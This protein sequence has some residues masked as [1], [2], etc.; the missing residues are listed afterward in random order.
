LVADWTATASSQTNDAIQITELR[1]TVEFLPHGLPQNSP[2][3]LPVVSNL[4]LEAHD[5]LR[6]GANSEVGILWPDNSVLRFGSLTELEILSADEIH[7]DRGLHLISGLLSF[8]HRGKPGRIRVITSGAFAGIEGTEF[9]VEVE[10]SNGVE[11]TTLSVIDGKVSFTNAMGGLMLTNGEQAVAH[12]GAAPVRT[13]GFIANNVLQ[14][15]FY[16]P[17]VLDTKELPGFTDEEK[18]SLG[19]SLAEYRAGDLLAAL[20]EFTDRP[21]SEAARIYHAALLLS[22]GQEADAAA[23]LDQST[24]ANI[25][26]KSVRLAAALRT[27]IAAVKRQPQAQISNPQLATEF[28]AASYYEQ[29]R[30]IPTLL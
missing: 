9:V 19:A 25:S 29:S 8:F 12:P 27:L 10:P 22:A 7:A 23:E 6:T 5:L 18:S 4:T 28:L 24:S 16:Y 1:G 13:A 3:W 20:R 26:E 14:W 21:N 2:R 30:A 11:Q 17:G 15:C